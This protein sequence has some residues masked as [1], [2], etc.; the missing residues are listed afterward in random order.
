MIG[1]K[2]LGL[3]L[4][5]APV[6]SG[7]SA[8]CDQTGVRALGMVLS[9]GFSELLDTATGR[10]GP[11]GDSHNSNWDYWTHEQ[12]QAAMQGDASSAKWGS[13][14]SKIESFRAKRRSDESL[15]DKALAR[16]WL[17]NA[18]LW[19]QVPSEE[20]SEE[21]LSPLSFG[22]SLKDQG[23]SLKK[24]LNTEELETAHEILDDWEPDPSK[25][26]TPIL[27]FGT[28]PTVE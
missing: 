10:C 12:C 18:Y 19:T 2:H 27:I 11:I 3:V 26:D 23:E 9:A 16:W 21:P 7:C 28:P 1:W 15:T 13:H 14:N 25:C 24:R 17:I 8:R 6:L 5:I 4:I 22:W 20:A